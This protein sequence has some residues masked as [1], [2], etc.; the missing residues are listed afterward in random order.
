M[1]ANKVKKFYSL[2]LQYRAKSESSEMEWNGI[3]GVYISLFIILM[4]TYKLS[5]V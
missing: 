2:F 5:V 1:S 4:V 3:I